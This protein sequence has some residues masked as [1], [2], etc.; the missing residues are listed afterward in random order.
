M[1]RRLDRISK[2]PSFR[3]GDEKGQAASMTRG[4]PIL[5]EA[6]SPSA[7]PTTLR[8]LK[9]LVRCSSYSAFVSNQAVN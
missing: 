7:K 6:Q 5:A 1:D 3:R 9:S 8:S 4:T 2:Q